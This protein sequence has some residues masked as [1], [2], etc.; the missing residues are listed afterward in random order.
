MISAR[1]TKSSQRVVLGEE[2]GAASFSAIAPPLRPA[3]GRY[4]LSCSLREA[5]RLPATAW[6][7]GPYR[8]DI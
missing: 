5:R 4:Q 7:P 3:R 8:A 6:L 1:V 2:E